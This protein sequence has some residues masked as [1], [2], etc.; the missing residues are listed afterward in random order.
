MAGISGDQ[1]KTA[2]QGANPLDIG[3]I[4]AAVVIFLLSFFPYYTASVEVKGGGDLADLIGGAGST[5][6]SVSAWHGFFGWFAALVALAVA[7]VLVLRL[8]GIGLDA[9]TSRLVVLAGAGVVALCV[10]LALFVFPDG[11]ADLEGGFD[12]GGGI[13][14]ETSTGHGIGYWLSLL[15]AL[16]L[17]AVAAL[18][19]KADD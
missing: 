19:S 3:M 17:V 11:G 15:L 8:L 16:G 4:V 1:V 6:E 10:I 13:T 12:L 5:S 14:M 7:V 18:R 9:A 2:F